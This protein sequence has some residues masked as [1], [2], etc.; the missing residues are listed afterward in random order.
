METLTLSI[1]QSTQST[2]V[3][4]IDTTG[5]IIYKISRGHQQIINDQG[6]I[7]HDL[8]EIE[9]NLKTLIHTAVQH[10]NGKVISAVTI[11]NQR[12][13]AAAWRK[14]TG[15]PLSLSIVWQDNRAE[16]ITSQLLNTPMD[17]SIKQKTGLALS[18]YFTAAKYSWLIKNVPEVKNADEDHDLCLGT[19]DS[20]VL[21]KLTRGDV[22]KTEPSNACRTQLMNIH[23]GDWDTGI[24]QKFGIDRASLPSIVDS[25]SIFGGTDL[26]G[27]LNQRV[28]ITS[29]LGDSQAALYAEQC[30]NAGEFKVTF[31]TG[32]SI[33]LN[34]GKQCLRSD[35]GLNT[36][37]AWRKN[38]Q[39]TYVLE[40]NINYS[41]AIVTWLKNNLHLISDPSETDSMAQSA[42]PNDTT[43]LVPAFTGMAAP[44]NYPSL[45]ANLS[46]MTALTGRNEIVRA[47]LDAVVFQIADI[48]HLMQ[49]SFPKMDKIINVDGGMIKNHYL[50][51]RLSNIAQLDVQVANEQELSALG[52]ALNGDAAPNYRKDVSSKYVT[53]MSKVD[54]NLQK[55]SWSKAIAQ[56]TK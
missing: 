13:T 4:L 31:G 49:K 16:E 18:P 22:F 8:N 2:K 51:Q 23:T 21:Y 50:M 17:I 27:E 46:G 24:M 10:Q 41:G 38:N 6:W 30:Q 42:S 54:S 14:S 26:F 28:P 39:T 7:S 25:D 47:A 33:V 1:D 43:I 48:I 29:M 34:T 9:N 12:E 35:S 52:T 20:W 32:S 11:T 3:F 56:L 15:E 36:S 5:K 53:L 40:G 45:K 44:Y 19:M 37:I 55:E